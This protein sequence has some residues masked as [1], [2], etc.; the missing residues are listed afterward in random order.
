MELIEFLK[1]AVGWKSFYCFEGFSLIGS[2]VRSTYCEK[3]SEPDV[4]GDILTIDIWSPSGPNFEFWFNEDLKES[5]HTISARGFA[6]YN[7]RV[8]YDGEFILLY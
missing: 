6:I 5:K 1:E 8:L 4:D 2:Q 7:H 3:W